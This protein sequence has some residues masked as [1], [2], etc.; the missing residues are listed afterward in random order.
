M[1]N[2][3]KRI[4]GYRDLTQDD[5]DL[6]NDI[7]SLGDQIEALCDKVKT[8][9]ES[10]Q[11]IA[12]AYKNDVEVKRLDKASPWTWEAQA[13]RQYQLASMHLVRAVAQ[14]TTFC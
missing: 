7:K 12:S 11:L 5:V 8:R 9:I 10:Q 3:H 13:R 4:E 1:D 14:P 6:I 2:Q